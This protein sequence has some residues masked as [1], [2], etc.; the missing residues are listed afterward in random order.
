M[1]GVVLGVVLGRSALLA[2]ILAPFIKA[3]NSIPRIV[4]A[5]PGVLTMDDISIS[6]R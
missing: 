6:F 5:R 3:A 4:Q 1:A 2:D